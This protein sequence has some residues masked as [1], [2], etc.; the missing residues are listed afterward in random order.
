M[1]TKRVL[2]KLYI[3]QEGRV[4]VNEDNLMELACSDCRRFMRKDGENVAL[5]LHRFDFLGEYV[6]TVVRYDDGAVETVGR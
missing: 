3:Q 4:H 1:R 2:L 6:E 5:V